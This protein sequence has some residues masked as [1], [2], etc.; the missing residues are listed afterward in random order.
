MIIYSIYHT[1]R[2]NNKCFD[3]S[4]K[5][6]TSAK[7]LAKELKE[8]NNNNYWIEKQNLISIGNCP[9]IKKYEV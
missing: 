8:L 6:L 7:T 5:T 4:Y 3:K 9:T 1:G 2:K